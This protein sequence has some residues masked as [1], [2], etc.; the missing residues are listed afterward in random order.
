MMDKDL[1]RTLDIAV[2]KMEEIKWEESKEFLRNEFLNDWYESLF[3]HVLLHSMTGDPAPLINYLRS[4][5]P[6]LF[7][8]KRLATRL[9]AFLQKGRHGGRHRDVMAH[10]LAAQ[11][12]RLL[13]VWQ[14]EN[15]RQGVNDRGRSADMKDRRQRLHS[16]SRCTPSI[17]F[18]QSWGF[19]PISRQYA[20]QFAT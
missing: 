18:R 7:D 17:P 14:E 3:L 2:K 1:R 13:D 12:L 8:R 10:R 5:R 9:E 20:R 15:I 16:S 4:D 11:A 6:L 19:L